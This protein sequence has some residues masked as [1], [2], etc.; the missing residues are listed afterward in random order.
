MLL[1]QIHLIQKKFE[2]SDQNLNIHSISLLV[3]LIH[4]NQKLFNQ[5][6][7][8]QYKFSNKLTIIIKLIS[9]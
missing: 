8:D 6:L 3:G 7:R 2:L 5:F 1:Q 9:F 4:T